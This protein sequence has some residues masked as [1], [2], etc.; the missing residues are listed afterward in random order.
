MVTEQLTVGRSAR[1]MSG[2]LSSAL[3]TVK[4]VPF[5]PNESRM[6]ETTSVSCTFGPS[7]NVSA[8]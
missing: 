5:T 2:R 3:P 6:R 8:T 4:N 7:S 1:E